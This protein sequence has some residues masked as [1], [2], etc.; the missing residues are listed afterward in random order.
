MVSQ[1]EV[2]E[3]K[4]AELKVAQANYEV[5]EAAFKR[6][7]KDELA[8]IE[9]LRKDERCVEHRMEVAEET[10]ADKVSDHG[11]MY[12][13]GNSHYLKPDLRATLKEKFSIIDDEVHSIVWHAFQ[14]A[15]D[16]VNA[17]RQVEVQALRQK[18]Y[19][20]ECGSPFSDRQKAVRDL[21]DHAQWLERHIA[22]LSDLSAFRQWAKHKKANDAIEE[23]RRQKDGAREALAAWLAENIFKQ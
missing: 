20:I 18:R 10:V 11:S 13:S 3:Q 4:R 9:K 23:Q 15:K 8:A 6:D 12:V 17:E 14:A 5:A 1:K 21:R 16:K 19:A 7:F 2:L 22:L